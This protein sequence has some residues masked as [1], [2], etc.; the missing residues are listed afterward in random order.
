MDARNVL[1][2]LRQKGRSLLLG[3]DLELSGANSNVSVTVF[4][5]IYIFQGV[6]DDDEN[7]AFHLNL[8]ARL[9]R[10]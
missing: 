4:A 5:I 7:V 9:P 3:A 1:H 10:L 8:F 6:K 2:L